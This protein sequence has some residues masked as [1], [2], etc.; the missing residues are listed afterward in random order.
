MAA[1]QLDPVLVRKSWSQRY[2]DDEDNDA[3]LMTQPY[4]SPFMRRRAKEGPSKGNKSMSFQGQRWLFVNSCPLL[5]SL[6][7]TPTNLRAN[8]YKG[9]RYPSASIA[10]IWIGCGSRDEE[11]GGSRS[12]CQVLV[13]KGRPSAWAKKTA[14]DVGLKQSCFR[15]GT[16]VGLRDCRLQSCMWR[17]R[18]RPAL[19][20]FYRL[21][22]SNSI[23]FVPQCRSPRNE[24]RWP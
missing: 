12:P 1:V 21:N 5:I 9:T 14:E 10:Y 6:S 8:A 3:E 23:S 17:S 4:I 24:S 18:V 11:S 22:N 16:V 19:R 20:V 7:F 15:P 2:N 13:Q